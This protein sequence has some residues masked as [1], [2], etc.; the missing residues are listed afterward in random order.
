LI[1]IVIIIII[2]IIVIVNNLSVLLLSVLFI[3][4]E[5]KGTIQIFEVDLNVTADS[6]KSFLLLS[7]GC[8]S[9]AWISDIKFGLRGD[10]CLLAAGSHDKRL[11]VYS[12]PSNYDKGFNEGDWMSCLKQPK[13]VFNKHS[14]AVIHFDFSTDGL[15]VQT[16]CQAAELLFCNTENGKHE[17]SASKLAD[18]NNYININGDEEELD[19]SKTCTLGWPVQGIWFI[20]YYHDYYYY[21]FYSS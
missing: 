7:E 15:Y 12:V 3:D 18:Y 14:S 5:R 21:Y 8:E 2:I 6:T 9:I 10:E 20:Y 17:T 19:Q 1:I 13:F 16:N 11:Y 4:S